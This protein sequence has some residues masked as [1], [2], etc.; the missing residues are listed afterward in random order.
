MNYSP[1]IYVALPVLNESINIRKL[2]DSL[3]KQSHS[4]FILVACVNQYDSWWNDNDK[5]DVC[6]DNIKSI[7]LLKNTPN[8]LI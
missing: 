4:N 3:S 6:T 1:Y 7:G 5:I 8:P 2:L